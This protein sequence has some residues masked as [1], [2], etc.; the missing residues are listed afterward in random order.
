M[1]QTSA[2]AS[3]LLHSSADPYVLYLCALVVDRGLSSLL[4]A[5]S[6]VLRMSCYAEDAEDASSSR[7]DVES[8]QI[9]TLG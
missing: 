7:F 4:C 5:Y 8:Q 6:S 2:F 9:T 1:V 3:R